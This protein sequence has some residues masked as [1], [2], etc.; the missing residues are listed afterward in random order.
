MRYIFL[1]AIGLVLSIGVKAQTA[2]ASGALITWEASS[3]DFGDITQGD[4]VEFTFKFSNNG[5]EPLIITNVTTQCGCTTPKG[6]PRDPVLPGG[7]GEITLAFNSTGKF[8]RQNKVATVVSNAANKD[9]GQLVLSG[10]V[11]ER[12]PQ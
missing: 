8:G 5:T 9:G 12:K 3:H 7:S 2:Q 10:N 6:W 1:V 11:L 4:K